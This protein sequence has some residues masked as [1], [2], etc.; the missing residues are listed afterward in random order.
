MGL[1][2][3]CRVREGGRERSGTVLLEET[4]IVV[5]GRP[6]LRLPLASLRGAR[7][8]GGWLVL[9]TSQ[10]EVALELGAR[11][12]DWLARLSRAPRSRLDKLGLRPGQRLA[13]VGLDD[14]PGLA[15]ELQARGLQSLPLAAGPFDVV[16]CRID[17]RSGLE[18]L[19]GF[20]SR[21]SDSGAIWVVWPKGRK[22]LR[23]DDVRAAARAVGL[24]DVKVMS[25]SERLSGLK[26]VVPAAAR[27]GAGA[28][29]RKERA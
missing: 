25:F 27:G 23:E 1:E 16:L 14:E 21:I 18:A 11:A 19:S 26:L 3:T 12:G 4:E 5:A 17:E 13:V 7:Q 22:E 10:G 6:R 20:R 15:S 2:A 29:P 8:D 24:V 28:R 9:E